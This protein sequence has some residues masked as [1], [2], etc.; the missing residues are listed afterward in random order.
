[1]REATKAEYWQAYSRAS[2]HRRDCGARYLDVRSTDRGTEVC[3]RT[4]LLTRG[5]VTS[6]IYLVNPLF[7]RE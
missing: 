6:T 1:M 4:E 5:K 2:E 7:I 3:A